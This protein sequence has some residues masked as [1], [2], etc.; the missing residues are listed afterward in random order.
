MDGNN[1]RTEAQMKEIPVFGGLVALVDDE[2][3]EWLATR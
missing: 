3:Y 1:G 2:D